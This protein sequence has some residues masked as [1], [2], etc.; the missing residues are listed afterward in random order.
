MPVAIEQMETFTAVDQLAACLNQYV[1]DHII[2]GS[3]RQ[4]LRKI[5][6]PAGE[7]IK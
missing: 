4:Y 1:L 3:I 5:S 6:N 2:S 7:G